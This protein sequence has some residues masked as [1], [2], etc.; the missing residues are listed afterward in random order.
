MQIWVLR[1]TLK[2]GILVQDSVF[3]TQKGWLRRDRRG[4]AE[5]LRGAGLPSRFK[6]NPF[7]GPKT[8]SHPARIEDL[9]RGANKET[10][11]PLADWANMHF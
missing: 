10:C 9:K 11:P 2:N 4:G 8:A 5:F 7:C 6:S 1:S 3:A